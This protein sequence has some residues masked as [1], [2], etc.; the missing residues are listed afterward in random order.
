[1]GFREVSVVEVREVLRAWLGG[2]GLRTV[3][4][5]AGVDRKTAR[6]YVAAAEAAGLSRDDGLEGVTDDLVGLVVEAVRP[7]RPNGHGSSWQALLGYEEQI[8][9]WVG[10]AEVDGQRHDPLS[11]VKIEQLLARRGLV[12]PYR[13]L[14]RFAVERCGFRVGATTVRVVDGEPG[15]ECQL[16]FAQLGL[17][18][19]AETGRQ[20]RVHAL[21]FT[22]VLSRHLFVWLTFSQTLTAVIAGCEAAWAFFGGAYRVL[23]PDSL[24]AVVTTAD[25]VNPRL[26]PGWLDY[27]QHVGF[28]TDPTRIR[29]PQDKHLASHCTSWRWLG[30]NTVSQRASLAW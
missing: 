12:V 19:D 29:S 15:V 5:R 13:T 18:L 2:F 3:A 11:I 4:S 25:A 6:R 27:A 7:A 16:D 14:H 17:L 9:G 1:M 10:G 26:S 20:R 30:G 8:R 28:G 24:K 22:A 21:I 23:I